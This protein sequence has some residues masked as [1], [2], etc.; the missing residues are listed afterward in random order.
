MPLYNLKD[1]QVGSLKA[2]VVLAAA[3]GAITAKS[4]VVIITAAGAI[5]LTLAAPIA[6]ADDG[7]ELTII[8]DTAQAH[9]VTNAA[10]G[11]NGAGA[12]GDVATFTAA[13]GNG[14]QLVAY[15]GV[16]Y[17]IGLRGVALA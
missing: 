12:G 17:T 8:T 3:A 16:W 4:G 13:R 7:S 5:A 2:P 14:M 11:F 1:G 15:N 10:P 6:G 9:T